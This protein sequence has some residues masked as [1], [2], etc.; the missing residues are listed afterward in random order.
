MEGNRRLQIAFIVVS[1]ALFGFA[2]GVGYYIGKGAGIEEEKK[3][4]EMEKKQIVKTLARITPVS[5]PEPV[6]ETVKS[7]PPQE[8]NTEVSPKGENQ[9]PTEETA[10]ANETASKENN[11]TNATA[12]TQEKTEEKIVV[13]EET[14]PV[15]ENEKTHQPVQ[16]VV[17]TKEEVKPKI[18]G[19]YY[20]QLGIFRNKENAFKL[21]NR[22]KEKGF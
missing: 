19:K 5:R 3:I 12:P 22:L 13:K 18:E 16:Q 7:E 4:C 2:Y 8:N 1:A 21:V 9:V 10:E 6:E 17:Q 14:K 20:L 15:E 11:A